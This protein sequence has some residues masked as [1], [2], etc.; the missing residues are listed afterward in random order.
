MDLLY[1]RYASPMDL[2]HMYFEQGRFG[3]F[4]ENIVSLE[5][6]RRNAE[7]EKENE[8]ML[9]EMYIH[10]MSNES[11]RDWRR[12]VLGGSSSSEST[13]SGGDEDLTDSE[14]TDIINNTFSK[15]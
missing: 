4:V 5:K 7:I 14:I 12:R 15:K 1:S 6:E 13:S 2:M 10:S 3:E 8:R 11:Y 9:W